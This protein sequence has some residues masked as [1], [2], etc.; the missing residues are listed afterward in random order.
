MSNEYKC[1]GCGKTLRIKEVTQELADLGYCPQCYTNR[2]EKVKPLPPSPEP[3]LCL[4]CCKD[5]P[6]CNGGKIVWGIDRHPEVRGADADK[7]LECDAYITK[8]SPQSLD[9][10]ANTNYELAEIIKDELVIAGITNIEFE[11]RLNRRIMQAISQH[12]PSKGVGQPMREKIRDIWCKGCSTKIEPFNHCLSHGCGM[13]KNIQQTLAALAPDD[14]ALTTALFYGA[15]LERERH[16][17]DCHA[18]RE[19]MAAGMELNCSKCN[20]AEKYICFG[21]ECISKQL[22][23]D[24]KY[25]RELPAKEETK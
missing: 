4:T 18:C 16:R 25:I 2:I 12:T 7:V 10:M 23:A 24:Q 8:V 6:T 9:N 17:K 1:V 14:D 5:F 20:D 19:K 15:Q 13:A 3:H 21:N 22:D 11:S